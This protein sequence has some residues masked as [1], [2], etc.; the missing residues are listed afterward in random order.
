MLLILTGIIWHIKGYCKVC[1]MSRACF[2]LADCFWNAALDM[3]A[4]ELSNRKQ[5]KPE[6][7]WPKKET[8]ALLRSACSALVKKQGLYYFRAITC[9]R[10]SIGAWCQG[11]L[12]LG[13]IVLP[14]Y[15]GPCCP[16]RRKS[17]EYAPHSALTL[18]HTSL[19]MALSKLLGCAGEWERGRWMCPDK[20]V[21]FWRCAACGFPDAP[22][23]LPAPLLKGCVSQLLR[24]DL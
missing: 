1:F 14:L 21:L 6:K 9:V 12:G 17:K 15:P 23:P 18:L 13:F 7:I 10:R 5:K 4:G 8:P 24:T 3:H 2:L 22:K 11:E 19:G 16:S 20:G